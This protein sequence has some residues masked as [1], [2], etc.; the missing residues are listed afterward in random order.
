[1][2]EPEDPHIP[3]GAR[4]SAENPGRWIHTVQGIGTTPVVFNDSV[5]R[6]STDIETNPIPDTND[7]RILM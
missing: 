6:I 1:M 2:I 7:D 5:D 4:G 3:A